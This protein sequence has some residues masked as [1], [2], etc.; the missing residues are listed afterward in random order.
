[1]ERQREILEGGGTVMQ[2]TN[3]WDA[4]RR[5]LVMMRAKEHA[6]DYRYFNEPDLLPLEVSD[7]WIEKTRSS[8]PELP[9]ARRRRFVEGYGLSVYDAGVLTAEQ[10]V[11]DYFEEVAGVTGDAKLSANWVMRE[12]ME[13][14]KGREGGIEAFPVVPGRL[15]GLVTLV[16]DGVISTTAGRDVFMEMMESGEEAGAV[17]TRLGLEQISA[18][19]ELEILVDDVLSGL[20]AE[21]E[22]FRGG[23]KKLFPFF[24]GRVMKRSG[25]K[26]NPR[27]LSDILRR[28]LEG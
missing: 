16:K 17:V 2:V 18:E 26:A 1:M 14:L 11:A 23:E 27:L 24:V 3:L 4:S 20:S 6:H 15:A 8:I 21:I 22:R 9:A 28:K 25:G 10:G 13:T 7:A 5:R 12:V 19:R